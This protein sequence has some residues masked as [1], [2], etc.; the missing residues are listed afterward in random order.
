MNEIIFDA[1]INGEDVLIQRFPEIYTVAQQCPYSGG[2]EVYRARNVL[3]Y[4][5]DSTQFPDKLNCLLQGFYRYNN[6][7]LDNYNAFDFIM[8]PNPATNRV[9][10]QFLTKLDIG[11]QIMLC[12]MLGQVLDRWEVKQDQQIITLYLHKYLPGIYILSAKNKE[13]IKQKK[14]IIKK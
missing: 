12:S 13:N 11:T 4:L 7:P 1:E 10:V 6:V 3:E 14:L 9:N 5:G 8:V 2:P